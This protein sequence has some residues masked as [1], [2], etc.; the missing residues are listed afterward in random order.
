[1]VVFLQ[2]VLGPVFG[3]GLAVSGLAQKG[4]HVEN[5]H[6]SGVRVRCHCARESDRRAKMAATEIKSV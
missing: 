3:M 5:S 2:V 1:M 4:V 6:A